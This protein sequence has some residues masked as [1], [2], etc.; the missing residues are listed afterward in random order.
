MITSL[1]DHVTGE[2]PPL[3]YTTW[4]WGE[5]GLKEGLASKGKRGVEL[6]QNGDLFFFF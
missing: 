2:Y 3:V 4:G 5:R 1:A 6:R